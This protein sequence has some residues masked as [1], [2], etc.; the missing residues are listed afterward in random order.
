LED[1]PKKVKIVEDALREIKVE[2][3]FHIETRISDKCSNILTIEGNMWSSDGNIENSITEAKMK[4]F[5]Q[6]RNS[7][8]KPN[9]RRV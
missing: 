1:F 4:A 5:V 7:F 6:K 8:E 9:W 2:E 3:E